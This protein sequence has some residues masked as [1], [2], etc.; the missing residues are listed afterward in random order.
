[1]LPQFGQPLLSVL[2]NYFTKIDKLLLSSRRRFLDQV[3]VLVEGAIGEV[4][5]EVIATLK[6]SLSVLNTY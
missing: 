4:R 5:M 6:I 2:D 1:M 3:L